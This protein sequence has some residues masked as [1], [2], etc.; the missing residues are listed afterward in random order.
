MIQNR[1]G[2]SSSGEP[3]G[4]RREANFV[5]DR[6]NLLLPYGFYPQAECSYGCWTGVPNGRFRAGARSG[7]IRRKTI[8]I[9]VPQV[10]HTRCTTLVKI[11]N[12]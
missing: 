6:H 3:R 8:G 5:P 7:A 1:R 9:T 4:N 12:K 2:W 10:A 11:C